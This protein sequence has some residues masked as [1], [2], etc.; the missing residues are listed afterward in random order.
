[1]VIDDTHPSIV[2]STNPPWILD[3]TGTKDDV[4][5]FGKTLNTTLHGTPSNGSFSFSFSGIPIFV[6]VSRCRVKISC[7]GTAIDIY[8]T[9]SI[10]NSS[11]VID[12]AWSCYLNGVQLSSLPPFRNQENNWRMCGMDGLLDMNHTF[13]LSVSTLGQL[14]WFDYLLY[15]PSPSSALQNVPVVLVP[16][17]DSTL[18][19][20]SS[21]QFWSNSSAITRTR[22]ASVQ[23]QFTGKH[24]F[25]HPPFFF[26]TQLTGTT[27]SWYGI[28][29]REL[30]IQPAMASFSI[31]G[32]M[33]NTFR[34]QGLSSP[35]ASTAYNQLLFR[36]DVYPYGLHTIIVKFEG[37]NNTTPLSLAYI[38]LQGENVSIGTQTGPTLTA[39]SIA[40]NANRPSISIAG[41]VCGVVALCV[42]IALLLAYFFVFKK[43]RQKIVPL[44]IPAT[45]PNSNLPTPRFSATTTEGF[46]LASSSPYLG[47]EGSIREDRRQTL[48][49]REKLKTS[50]FA[51]FNQTPR[52]GMVVADVATASTTDHRKT[53]GPPQVL[54]LWARRNRSRQ[55]HQR[56]TDVNVP[57]RPRMPPDNHQGLRHQTPPIDESDRLES[58]DVVENSSGNIPAASLSLPT[59]L[60]ERTT[61][62]A[63]VSYYGG[64]RTK[65]EM[66]ELERRQQGE[67]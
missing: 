11:G 10:R 34:L 25:S 5:N 36:T 44:P 38:L 55:I 9:N 57:H 62:S 45:I 16:F 60:V 42:V 6:Y 17:S 20:D 19:Y 7:T 3:D 46:D 39:T 4:G 14:F 37:N 53:R 30:P 66:I 64:Y 58:T 23:F 27:L 28:Y 67:L 2:Y 56:I 12:P 48:T 41:L 32:G 59:A 29:P 8:G 54:S 35:N 63:N 40:S 13:T 22:K 50:F 26:L 43:R 47:V 61:S 24:H 31:D 18:V 51:A 21:W 49:W 33:E 15:T 65:K 52:L 1:V